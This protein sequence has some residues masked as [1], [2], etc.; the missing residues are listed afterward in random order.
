MQ[1]TKYCLFQKKSQNIVIEQA[2]ILQVIKI[3]SWSIEPLSL[4]MQNQTNTFQL[5]HKHKFPTE[6]TLKATNG[7]SA[8]NQT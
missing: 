1:Y 8:V 7:D 5:L 6:E 4:S 2:N 3:P